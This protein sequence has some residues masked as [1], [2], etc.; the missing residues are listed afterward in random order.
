MLPGPGQTIRNAG[1]K[2]MYSNSLQTLATIAPGYRT[3]CGGK[4]YDGNRVWLPYDCRTMVASIR[5]IRLIRFQFQLS[6][7]EYDKF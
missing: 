6:N 4:E 1:S 2:P 7:F 3:G 5:L